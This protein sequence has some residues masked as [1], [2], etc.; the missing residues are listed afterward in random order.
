[1]A[2]KMAAKMATLIFFEYFLRGIKNYKVCNFP[3]FR[4]KSL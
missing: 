3:V 2:A 1:M 4:R